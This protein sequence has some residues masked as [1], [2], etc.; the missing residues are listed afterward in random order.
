[1]SFF[2]LNTNGSFE[3]DTGSMHAEALMLTSTKI[4]AS[5]FLR[6][7]PVVLRILGGRPVSD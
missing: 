2:I 1:M 7:L 4:N 3:I 5:A 6:H